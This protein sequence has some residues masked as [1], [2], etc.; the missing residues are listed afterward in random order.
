MGDGI[1]QRWETRR[2]SI[3][4]HDQDVWPERAELAGDA[5]FGVDL[6]IEQRSG[7]GSAGAQSEQDDKQAAVIGSK[8]TSKDAPE[9]LPIL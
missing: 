1:G 5:V 8:Q 6:E 4:R 7:Y 2:R 3:P 9:H